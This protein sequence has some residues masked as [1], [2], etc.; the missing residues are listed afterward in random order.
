MINNIL[1]TIT[2]LYGLIKLIL[3]QK[4]NLKKENMKE[5]IIKRNSINECDNDNIKLMLLL[6]F[7]CLNA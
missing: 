3:T 6:L 5:G 4:K 1:A 2:K 7:V